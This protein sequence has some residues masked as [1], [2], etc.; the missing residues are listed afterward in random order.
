MFEKIAT[1]TE[2]RMDLEDARFLYPGSDL[3]A[4]SVKSVAT[5]TLLTTPIFSVV[6]SKMPK[7]RGKMVNTN[8]ATHQS[9]F[10]IYHFAVYL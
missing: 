4:Q 6:K 5:D 10:T 1:N 2:S 3:G 7:D 8:C 9:T